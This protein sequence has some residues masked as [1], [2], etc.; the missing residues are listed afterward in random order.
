MKSGFYAQIFLNFIFIGLGEF[1]G[2][3]FEDGTLNSVHIVS[4]IFQ[5]GMNIRTA[6]LYDG[7]VFDFNVG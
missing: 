2:C 3:N 6:R 1:S 7:F 4:A 5:N